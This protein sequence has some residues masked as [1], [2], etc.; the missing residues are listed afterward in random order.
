M[1]LLKKSLILFLALSLGLSPLV[2]LAHFNDQENSAYNLVSCATLDF[3]LEAPSDF[4]RAVKEIEVVNLG[5]INFFYQIETANAS[6]TLCDY[7]N[8]SASLNGSLEYGGSLSGLF[9]NKTKFQSP[10]LWQFSAT[11]STTSS[12]LENTFCNFD[13]V[14]NGYQTTSSLGFYDQEIINNTI[15]ANNWSPSPHS[16]FTAT[17]NHIIE[18]IA[19]IFEQTTST[20][21]Q[22]STSTIVEETTC[23]PIES[24]SLNDVFL[25][26]ENPLTQDSLTQ[27][28]QPPTEPVAEPEPEPLPEPQ[29]GQ[30]EPEL[31]PEPEAEPELDQPEPIQQQEPS[32]APDEAE[33]TPEPTIE[34][35]E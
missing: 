28:Q 30:T 15:T 11:L 31:N 24:T 23:Q 32:P 18:Q 25:F 20:D 14:F 19:T 10:Q 3:A 7:L 22:E 13:F 16:F 27:E 21:Q 8:I 12:S 17:T 5:T 2:A 1:Q 9:I 6:G 34:T 35:S 4:V 33:P 26:T 29:I